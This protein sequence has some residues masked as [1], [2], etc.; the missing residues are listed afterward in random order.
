MEGL[1]PYLYRLSQI[2]RAIYRENPEDQDQDQPGM[3]PDDVEDDR[4][5]SGKV[6][7][8]TE[9]DSKSLSSYSKAREIGL[10]SAGGLYSKVGGQIP[11]IV[12]ST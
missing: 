10:S 1:R 7:S 8:A 12:N 9:I 4:C 11:S 6:I 2:R 3:L 5:F